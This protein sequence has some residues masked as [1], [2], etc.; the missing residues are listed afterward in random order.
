MNDKI[1]WY[2]NNGGK[3]YRSHDQH[4][5]MELFLFCNRFDSDGDID[6]FSSRFD[7][8]IAWYE[9]N[10]CR[11]FYRSHDQYQRNGAITVFAIDKLIVTEISMF[12][13]HLEDDEIAW[14]ENNGSESFTVKIY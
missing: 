11:E 9:N 6:V 2:E 12:Y 10:G 7:D 1:A 8:K 3:F 13:P 4:N 14:Y 5:A